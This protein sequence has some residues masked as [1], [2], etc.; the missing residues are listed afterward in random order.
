MALTSLHDLPAWKEKKCSFKNGESFC[1]EERCGHNSV[2]I[3]EE[4]LVWGG[5]HVDN[6]YEYCENKYL[7]SFNLDLDRWVKLKPTGQRPS[8][9]SGASSGLL[10]PHWYI[11]GGCARANFNDI[12]TLNLI[13][14]IWEKLDVQTEGDQALSP[15]DKAATWVDLNLSR[16]YTFGGYGVHPYNFLWDE[17]QDLFTWDLEN[18]RGWNNQLVYFDVQK[19]CWVEPPCQGMKPCTRAAHASVN[20]DG[21]IYVFGGRHLGR[22]MNDLH[23]LTLRSH[24]WS[25]LLDCT[26]TPPVGRSWHTF[27]RI[28]PNQLILYGGYNT[29]ERP[30]DDAWLLNVDSLAWSEL[31]QSTSFPRLW[32]TA[33][34]NQYGDVLVFGGC[35]N[36][37][38]DH[39]EKMLTSEKVVVLRTSPFSLMRLCFHQAFRHR[40]ILSSDWHQLPTYLKDWLMEKEKLTQEDVRLG[41]NNPFV[42]TGVGPSISQLCVNVGETD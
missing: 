39:D 40:N 37:I 41:R 7:W 32:H 28:S 34:T 15:R 22:R 25:G 16:I 1:C 35:Y 29:E 2:C 31:R 33:A 9:R 14:L 20:V 30:L 27:S 6:A 36:N 42:L 23:R 8:G 21:D 13:T 11:F 17:K 18:G 38:L 3:K 24:H 26:G 4:L 10:W 19:K 12:Y 5:Y